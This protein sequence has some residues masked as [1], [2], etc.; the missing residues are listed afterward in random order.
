MGVLFLRPESEPQCLVRDSDTYLTVV[1]QSI[2]PRITDVD[3]SLYTYDLGCSIFVWVASQPQSDKVIRDI[4][5]DPSD[6][7]KARTRLLGTD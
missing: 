6:T 1:T 5:G 4:L 7:R 3:F 2:G